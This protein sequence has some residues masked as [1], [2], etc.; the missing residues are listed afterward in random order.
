[1]TVVVVVVLIMITLIMALDIRKNVNDIR[2]SNRISFVN[3]MCVSYFML[4]LMVGYKL[5][6]NIA[7]FTKN[8]L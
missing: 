1:M 6:F 7:K 8:R 5:Q 2:K 3:D 4:T